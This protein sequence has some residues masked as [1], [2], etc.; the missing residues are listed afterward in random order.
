MLKE[1]QYGHVIRETKENT[2]EMNMNEKYGR[3]SELL[4]KIWIIRL[5]DVDVNIKEK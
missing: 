5:H 3:T 4:R 1:E 2:V